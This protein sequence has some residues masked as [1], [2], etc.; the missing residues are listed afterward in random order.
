LVDPT[1]AAAGA[2][3]VNAFYGGQHIHGDVTAQGLVSQIVAELEQKG[4]KREDI[5]DEMVTQ[6]I[7]RQHQQAIEATGHE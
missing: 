6:H 1:L 7:E 2:A 5:T 4:M 3:R